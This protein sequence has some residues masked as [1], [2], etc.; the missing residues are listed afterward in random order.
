MKIQF[1]KKKKPL[2]W[3]WGCGNGSTPLTK[4]IDMQPPLFNWGSFR[5]DPLIEGMAWDHPYREDMA[6]ASWPWFFFCFGFF[7]FF[8]CYEINICIFIYFCYLFEEKR[9]KK[10]EKRKK[11]KAEVLD[12]KYS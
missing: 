11:K 10:K 4:V 1:K 3:H 6:S 12:L 9:K 2:K 8:F 7:F 5:G